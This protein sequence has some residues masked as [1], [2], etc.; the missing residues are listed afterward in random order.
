MFPRVTF[1]STV[2]KLPELLYPSISGVPHAALFS[3]RVNDNLQ[4]FLVMNVLISCQNFLS[5]FTTTT[6]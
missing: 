4:L 2:K 6:S 3:K 5:G 1:N